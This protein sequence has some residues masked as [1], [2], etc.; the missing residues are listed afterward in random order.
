MSRTAIVA[1][2]CDHVPAARCHDTS[3]ARQGVEDDAMNVRCLGARTI[4]PELGSRAVAGHPERGAVHTDR[5]PDLG[6][7]VSP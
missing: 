5:T 1:F 6:A 3:S 2:G 7:A 4:G